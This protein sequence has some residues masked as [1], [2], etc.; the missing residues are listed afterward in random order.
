MSSSV[1][2]GAVVSSPATASTKAAASAAL[3]VG[4]MYPL[5]VYL[6]FSPGGDTI[7]LMSS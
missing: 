3:C 1:N 4:H 5:A 2:V 6:N 7:S